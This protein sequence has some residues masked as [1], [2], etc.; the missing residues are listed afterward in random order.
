MEGQE[1]Q[2]LEAWTPVF[3][4]SYHLISPVGTMY[5]MSPG[6]RTGERCMGPGEHGEDAEQA[7]W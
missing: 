1:P 7:A 4:K 6:M 2:L 3:L 5:M